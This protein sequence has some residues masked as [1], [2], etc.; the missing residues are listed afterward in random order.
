MFKDV[1]WRE[2]YGL[3]FVLWHIK[4]VLCNS[5]DGAFAYLM[6]WF[7]Y[8]LQTCQKPGVLVCLYGAPGVGTSALVGNN[9]SGPGILARTYTT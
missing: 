4:F 3:Q 1:G 9:S 6:Q 2:T 8:T 5:D 7:G